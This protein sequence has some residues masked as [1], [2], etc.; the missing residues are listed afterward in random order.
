MTDL[1]GSAANRSRCQRSALI[2]AVASSPLPFL[3]R[4]QRQFGQVSLLEG[5]VSFL[6]RRMLPFVPENV[7]GS[8]IA[9]FLLRAASVSNCD[10]Q[11]ISERSGYCLFLFPRFLDVRVCSF[12]QF[13]RKIVPRFIF[14]GGKKSK[15]NALDCHACYVAKPTHWLLRSA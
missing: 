10:P 2:R 13:L 6:C 7:S 11:G 8:V 12:F 9:P 14:V 4:R 3:W 5:C 1:G 15:G